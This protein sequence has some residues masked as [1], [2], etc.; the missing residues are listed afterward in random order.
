MLFENSVRSDAYSGHILISIRFD[1]LHIQVAMYVGLSRRLRQFLEVIT[2]LHWTCI[3][4]SDSIDTSRRNA[5]TEIFALFTNISDYPGQLI[6]RRELQLAKIAREAVN[7]W[8]YI[9]SLLESQFI[10]DLYMIYRKLVLKFAPT[11]TPLDKML[12]GTGTDGLCG[13]DRLK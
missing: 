13:Y 7:V 10:S 12:K 4:R 1:G 2:T 6:W 8:K 5:E 3:S 9:P 11:F